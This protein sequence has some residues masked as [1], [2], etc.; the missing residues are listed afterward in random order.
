MM[1]GG[2][3]RAATLDLAVGSL[4]K[5]VVVVIVSAVF[6]AG[7]VVAI[8]PAAGGLGEAGTSVE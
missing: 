1:A 5:L 3:G 4:S 2:R 6:V 7:A 8:T